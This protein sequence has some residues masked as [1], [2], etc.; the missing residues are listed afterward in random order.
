MLFLNEW[1][2]PNFYV[3]FFSSECNDGLFGENCTKFCGHCSGLK[4]CH[5]ETGICFKGC[6]PG[7]MG[8]GCRKGRLTI[9]PYSWLFQQDILLAYFGKF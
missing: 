6:E 7:Y 9:L 4:A 2:I 1:G 3:F 5:H 8:K